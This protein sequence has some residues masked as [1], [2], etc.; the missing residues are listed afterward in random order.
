MNKLTEKLPKRY[1]AGVEK[2]MK[3]LKPP[4]PKGVSGNPNGINQLGRPKIADRLEKWG[5]LRVAKKIL[6]NLKTVFPDVDI[7][8]M[9]AT[10]AWT[11]KVAAAAIRGEAWAISFI[12]ERCEGKVKQS[13]EMSGRMGLDLHDISDDELDRRTKDAE[14]REAALQT[15]TTAANL[16][17]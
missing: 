7:S 2:R 6:Q 3:N 13:V 10:D 16:P 14:R 9:E 4:Y 11:M 8:K 5:R 1:A 15:G 12:A 17:Q